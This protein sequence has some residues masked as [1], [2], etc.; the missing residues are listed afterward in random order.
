MG[1]DGGS[2]VVIQKPQK[3]LY[4][5]LRQTAEMTGLTTQLIK[6]WEKEFDQLAPMRNR[7]GNRHYTENDILLL[8]RLKELLIEEK[9]SAEETREALKH[10]GDDAAA[11]KILHLRQALAEVKMEI[12]EILALLEDCF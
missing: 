10:S 3:K 5:S 6:N 2:Q 1:N 9:R 12:K 7:A 8:F 4:Y 11:K